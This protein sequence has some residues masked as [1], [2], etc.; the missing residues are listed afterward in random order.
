M[1]LVKM[2][3]IL[4]GGK[5]LPDLGPKFFELTVVGVW[6]GGHRHRCHLRSWG[7]VRFPHI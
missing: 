5:Q 2:P 7:T 1:P 3:K 6:H 4:L